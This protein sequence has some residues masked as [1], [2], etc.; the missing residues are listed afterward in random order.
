M[1]SRRACR[2]MQRVYR[3]QGPDEAK[4]DRKAH[5]GEDVHPLVMLQIEG[6]ALQ[7]VVAAPMVQETLSSKEV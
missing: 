3:L 1:W 6:G 5:V 2:T 4:H 7:P